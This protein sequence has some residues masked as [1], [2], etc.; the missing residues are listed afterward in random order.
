MDLYGITPQKRKH[1][2]VTL[3]EGD[4][5][6]RHCLHLSLPSYHHGNMV[7]WQ[8]CNSASAKCHV[9][10]MGHANLALNDVFRICNING[11]LYDCIRLLPHSH[12]KVCK[13]NAFEKEISCLCSLRN[14]SHICHM[15]I[16]HIKQQPIKFGLDEYPVC[17]RP[18]H[19]GHSADEERKSCRSWRNSPW[20]L[21]ALRSSS[22]HLTPWADIL[23]LGSW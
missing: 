11:R 10:E 22:T 20:T 4:L 1:L 13:L 6:G 2:N 23:L 19:E 21:E 3:K 9:W 12:T 14:S 18:I 15:A 5:C 8:Q 17:K 7:S 16:N